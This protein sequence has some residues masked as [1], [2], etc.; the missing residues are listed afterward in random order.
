MK[1]LKRSFAVILTL[2]LYFN[3]I[4]PSYAEETETK[5]PNEENSKITVIDEIITSYNNPNGRILCAAKYGNPRLY[6]ADSL[7]GIQSC[8]DMGV[9]IVTVS[10]QETKDKKLVLLESPSLKNMCVNKSDN[11]STSGNVK[12]YTLEELQEKFFLR[13]G[14]GGSNSKPTK[15]TIASLEDAIT[16]CKDSMM[17]MINNGWKYSDGIF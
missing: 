10:V 1:S 9:D 17:L 7:E 16:T 6:P 13:S 4:V 5:T 12:D 2:L 3:F 15:Y 11:T 8:I 14:C